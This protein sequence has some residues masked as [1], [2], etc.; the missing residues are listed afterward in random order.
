MLDAKRRFEFQSSISRLSRNTTSIWLGLALS[1]GVFG[2]DLLLPLGAA[3]GPCYVLAVFTTYR[4]PLRYAV[5]IAVLATVM[6]IVATVLAQG[7]AA[8][9]W[10]IALNR[11][12]A[13]AAIWASVWL[14]HRAALLR[15]RLRILEAEAEA[16]RAWLSQTIASIA[17]GVIACGADGRIKFMNSVSEKLT[18]WTESAAVG[19]SIEKVFKLK[20]ED[21]GEEIWPPIQAVLRGSITYLPQHTLLR[22]RDGTHRPVDDSASPIRNESGE[23]VGAVMVFR[24]ISERRKSELQTELRLREI[25]HRIKNVFANVHSILSLCSRSTQS[26]DELVQCVESRLAGLMRSTDRLLH[27]SQNG[28]SLREIVLEEVEPYLEQK[29]DRF[30]FAGVDVILPPQAAV[31]MGMIIH[32]LAT[33]ASKHGSLATP[34]GRVAVECGRNDDTIW[35]TWSENDGPP[36]RPPEHSGMGTKIIEGP[37]RT[38]FSGECHYSYLES[39]LHCRLKL[40]LPGGALRSAQSDR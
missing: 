35:L 4:K 19:Q 30:H 1:C 15:D 3:L 31:S 37:I 33:N 34:T 27:S 38:Q 29:R 2:L 25:G 11:G 40:L 22:S 21:T 26:S 32:E 16:R 18:G 12:V 14:L 7:Q 9:F 39:G 10:V 6:T 23:I 20:I 8:P 13:L 28:Y 5:G 36:A 24:D 17:D